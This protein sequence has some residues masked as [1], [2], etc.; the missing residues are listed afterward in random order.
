MAGHALSPSGLGPSA[1]GDALR[2]PA[3]YQIAATATSVTA[4]WIPV[5]A[6]STTAITGFELQW[7]SDSAARWTQVTGI[8]ST[9]T[10]HTITGLE[11]DTGYQV[12]VRA[13]AGSACM[14]RR[15]VECAWW[16][17]GI[18]TAGSGSSS[19]PAFSVGWEEPS[20]QEGDG[21]MAFI[22]SSEDMVPDALTVRVYV[23]A[24][25]TMLESPGLHRVAVGATAGRTE[26]RVPIA[27][28]ADA[29]DEPDCTVFATLILVDGYWF[30]SSPTATVTVSDDD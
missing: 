25:G 23:V 16:T 26:V 14:D 3:V 27:L 18:G 20:Y 11:P 1:P 7:R 17:F 6:G 22:L 24:C 10:W 8:A 30:G 28:E 19:E 15:S 9:A 5:P 13:V 12:R 2:A 4:F 21:E 29:V